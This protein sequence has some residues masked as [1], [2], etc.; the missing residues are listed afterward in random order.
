MKCRLILVAALLMSSAAQA[1]DQHPF[2]QSVGRVVKQ[3]ELQQHPFAT[4]NPFA[5]NM[6]VMRAQT[7]LQRNQDRA[8]KAFKLNGDNNK[9]SSR[10]NWQAPSQAEL[11]HNPTMP[12]QSLGKVWG[13]NTQN[14]VRTSGGNN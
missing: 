4:T 5:T 13:Q 11:K 9:S 12:K 3:V 6:P 2:G 14:A 10:Q 7:A 1:Q 8:A